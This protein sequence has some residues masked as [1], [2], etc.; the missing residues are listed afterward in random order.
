MC[1]GNAASSERN[2]DSSEDCGFSVGRNSLTRFADLTVK[3]IACVMVGQATPCIKNLWSGLIRTYFSV[4][5]QLKGASCF[6]AIVAALAEV[7]VLERD[8]SR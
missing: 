1:S 7:W 2:P 3:V 6:P 4:C 5:Y 8:T